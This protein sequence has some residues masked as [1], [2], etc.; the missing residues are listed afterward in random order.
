MSALA[1]A[2]CHVCACLCVPPGAQSQR[3]AQM[4]PALADLQDVHSFLTC[5]PPLAAPWSS[6]LTVVRHEFD[7][8][9]GSEKRNTHTQCSPRRTWRRRKRTTT[10]ARGR[11]HLGR[12]PHRRGRHRP[13]R[14][15]PGLPVALQ[16]CARGAPAEHH[17]LLLLRLLQRRPPPHHL[18]SSARPAAPAC[19]TW[20][21][22]GATATACC[23]PTT[24]RA[25]A[26]GNCS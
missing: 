22:S 5:H 23:C 12:A 4:G 24:A 3:S 18:Q 14:R 17:R 8:E 13:V 2:L 25:T 6:G 16:R 11:Q 15:A 20:S 21:S 7:H 10:V 26:D 1:H 9:A 19:K